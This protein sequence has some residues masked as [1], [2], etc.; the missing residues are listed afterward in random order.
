M[1]SPYLFDTFTGKKKYE[2]NAAVIRP[3][4]TGFTNVGN[5]VESIAFN[6]SKFVS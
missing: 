5:P 2:K 1:L 3:K 4:N 6:E